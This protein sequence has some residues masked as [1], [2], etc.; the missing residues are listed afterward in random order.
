MAKLHSDKHG[1]YVIAG[2]Y[3]FRP[4]MA[5]HSYETAENNFGRG[6]E[7]RIPPDLKEVKARHI[8]GTPF[9][10][11]KVGDIEEIWNSHGI[12]KGAWDPRED[13]TSVGPDA[14]SGNRA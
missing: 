4:Q 8:G 1:L 9:G 3:T 13:K 14:V 10:R 6:I 12:E 2:G 5:R 7:S 11:V